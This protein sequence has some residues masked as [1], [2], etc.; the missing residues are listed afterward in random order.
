M[1]RGQ[2]RFA[3][4]CE[5]VANESFRQIQF[6][7]WEIA[8]SRS[9][10][11]VRLS[12]ILSWLGECSVQECTKGDRGASRRPTG[13]SRSPFEIQIEIMMDAQVFGPLS[14]QEPMT[15]GLMR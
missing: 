7:L 9:G 14:G 4:Q 10:A 5:K 13:E 2:K 11:T 1:P 12:V 8:C 6:A 15:A 3:C